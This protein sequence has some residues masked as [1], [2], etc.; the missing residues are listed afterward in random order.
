MRFIGL[1]ISLVLFIP[2]KLLVSQNNSAQ[3]QVKLYHMFILMLI[4]RFR[5]DFFSSETEGKVYHLV[6]QYKCGVVKVVL[7]KRRQ[8]VRDKDCE[9]G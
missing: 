1:S 8:E 4:L 9:V 7:K 5:S 2:D 6:A 3:Y